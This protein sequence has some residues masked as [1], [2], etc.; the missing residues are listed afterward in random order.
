MTYQ[1]FKLTD[2]WRS[3][4]RSEYLI[5]QLQKEPYAFVD[6][7]GEPFV[8]ITEIEKS[9]AIS[10]FLLPISDLVAFTAGHQ[11]WGSASSMIRA[12]EIAESE[13]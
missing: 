3:I 1:I 11:Y 8:E 2:P 4:L 5:F 12:L 13:T 9:G 7:T 10:S 6:L